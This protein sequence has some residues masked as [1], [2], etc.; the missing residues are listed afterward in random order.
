MPRY[1]PGKE[2]WSQAEID[3]YKRLHENALYRAYDVRDAEE[4]LRIMMGSRMIRSHW[5][6][7]KL[8]QAL[9]WARERY[10]AAADRNNEFVEEMRLKYTKISEEKEALAKEAVKSPVHEKLKYAPPR[11]DIP[12]G[13]GYEETKASFGNG[14][15]RRGRR[16]RKTRRKH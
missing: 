8:I 16:A 3:R 11:L 7:E 13:P 14:R 5:E 2:V 4:H 9:R 12:G 15:T 10:K 6:K 1:I